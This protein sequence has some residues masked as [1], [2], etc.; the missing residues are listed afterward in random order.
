MASHFEIERSRNGETEKLLEEMR[1]ITKRLIIQ[2]L[3][4]ERWCDQHMISRAGQPGLRQYFP[5]LVQGRDN[6]QMTTV[7][8]TIARE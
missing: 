4:T 6:D 7:S 8:A 5:I 1:D 2:G 3:A